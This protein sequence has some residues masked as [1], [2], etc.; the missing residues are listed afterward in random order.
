M[1]DT[2]VALHGAAAIDRLNESSFR[3]RW[4]RLHRQSQGATAFQGVAFATAWYATYLD[5]WEP[6]LLLSEDASEELVGLWPLARRGRRWV[7]AGAHQA[8]YQGWLARPTSEADFLRNAVNWLRPRLDKQGMRVRYLLADPRRQALGEI[9]K[10]LFHVT[11]HVRP[12][13]KLDAET[14][15]SS[16]AK[17]ANKSR[18]NRLS[19]LGDFRFERLHTMEQ[20]EPHLARLIAYYDLR[21]GAVNHSVPFREDPRKQAF[22]RR[23]LNEAGKDVI[24][25]ISSLNGAAVAGFWGMRSGVPPGATVHLGMLIHSP[26]IA[27]HSPGKL[28]LMKL[29]EALLSEGVSV[30]DLTPGGDP[31]KER[32]A[33]AHDDAYELRVFPNRS[34]ASW[35]AWKQTLLV[36]VKALLSRAGLSPDRL[37][38]LLSLV[39][40]LR[41]PARWQAKA[42]QALHWM[43]GEHREYRLYRV[44]RE[45]ASTIAAHAER[46]PD[47]H[48]NEPEQLLEF[49][50]GESWQSRESFW[51]Q[52]LARLEAGHHAYTVSHGGRL[53]HTG[54]LAYGETESRVSEVGQTVKL[55]EGSASLYDFYTHPA[56]RGQGLYRASLRAMLADAFARHETRWAYIGVLADNRASRHVIESLGFRYLGSLHRV[57][58]WGRARLTRDPGLEAEAETGRLDGTP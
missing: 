30:I 26:M 48:V 54:W 7:V 16:L 50:P 1:K 15:R 25:S 9:D 58:R 20:V 36:R 22:H 31:W 37:H 5:I 8:E 10:G 45:Q 19:R 43:L 38:H 11:H 23:L 40:K 29:A 35:L 3:D 57:R 32:F 33:N 13:L 41:Q 14:V 27:A 34:A 28:H 17:K 52:A 21:Q 39:G 49:V 46:H 24:V 2:F 53:Q 4:S 56:A 6:V 44:D 18:L 55:P 47:L 51:S 12:L 42:R